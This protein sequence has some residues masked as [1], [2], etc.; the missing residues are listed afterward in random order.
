MIAKLTAALAF[1]SVA[2]AKLLYVGVNEAGMEFGDGKF[3][4]Q[5]NKDYTN[6]DVKTV[7][8]WSSLGANIFR[9]G[10][11]MERAMPTAGGAFNETYMGYLDTWINEATS[12]SNGNMKVLLDPHN[13]A[14]YYGKII[15][16]DEPI[17]TLVGFWVQLALRYKDNPNVFFDIMN[18]PHDMD[19]QLWWT[20]AQATIDAIR[21]VGATNLVLVPGIAWT[22]AWSWQ[23][24][25]N[26]DIAA[27]FHDDGNNFAFDMH[28]YLDT[29]YSGTSKVCSHT[30]SEVLS[31][32]TAWLKA[33]NMKAFLGEFGVSTDSSCSGVI[34]TMGRY[35][36]DNSDVWIGATWWA[37]GPWW[38]N[39]MY[40]AEPVKG[41]STPQISIWSAFFP[42]NDAHSGS[43]IPTG[44]ITVA[45]P[46]PT[47]TRPAPTGTPDTI[48][49]YMG[50][51]AVIAA[52]SDWS[53]S[54]QFFFAQTNDPQPV[55]GGLVMVAQVGAYGGVSYQGPDIT[56]AYSLLF[57]VA[58]DTTPSFN[59]HIDSSTEDYS[60]DNVAIQ[61]I[62]SGTI[63]A[64]TFVRCELKFQDLG[65]HAW[66]RVTISSSSANN[67]TL[68]FSEFIVLGQAEDGTGGP[69]TTTTTTGPTSTCNG[70][71]TV[72]QTET[73]TQDPV[74]ITST[75]TQPASTVYQT[76][77]STSVRTVTVSGGTT[78]QNNNN[79]SCSAKYGQCGGNGWTGP[80]CC[81]SGSSCQRQNDYYSQCL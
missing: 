25:G 71:Q 37:A 57:Y 52:W 23:S 2:A 54:S 33:H 60:S 38:G 78:T 32:T 42:G 5:Y 65:F 53:W 79:G 58:S 27:T 35:L 31:S 11:L 39:Y 28:Q 44:T 15:G 8:Y 26:A 80:K 10:F 6:P 64:H 4:G 49:I 14:R 74:T 75:Y 45:P 16:K 22:G 66:D 73:Y 62:C 56:Y 67:Q 9:T 3:P 68:V 30:P 59:V 61:D 17:G 24:S 41:A 63:N 50:G 55:V 12:S 19:A 36:S 77:T 1:A 48:P 46:S 40:G 51:D 13:Y 29:D 18:E 72:T 21:A 43:G 81:Q 70:A 7:P 76:I 47:P 20:A 69:T 34:E